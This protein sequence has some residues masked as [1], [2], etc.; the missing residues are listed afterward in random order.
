MKKVILKKLTLANWKGQTR[1]A[2][3]GE[4]ENNISGRNKSGKTTLMKAFYW[5]LSGYSDANTA[6][7]SDLFDNTKELTEHTPIASV[8]AV[9]NID[10][11][12][13]T[14]K[15]SAEAKCTRKRGTET[16]E[17]A[18]SD[19]YTYHIDNIER[20]STDFKAWLSEM[21]APE[22][23]LRFVL[24]GNFFI[25]EVFEDK[26]KARQLIEK[27]VG[28]VSRE[29]MK[30][31]YDI[32]DELIGR[33]TLDQIEMQATEMCKNI[34]QRLS[35]IPVAI[36]SKQNEIDIIAQTDFNAIQRDI[37]LLENEEK[38]LNAQIFDI[39]ARLKPQLEAK[40]KAE[41]G[42]RMATEIFEKAK[43]GYQQQFIDADNKLVAEIGRMD[44]ENEKT[45]QRKTKLESDNNLL[46]SQLTALNGTIEQLR[47]ERET[48]KNT[49]FECETVCPTCGAPISEEKINEAK[50]KFEQKQKQDLEG[51]VVRGKAVRAE[52]DRINAEIEKNAKEMLT[53]TMLDVEPVR[54]K[55][56]DLRMMDITPF[57]ETEQGVMLQKDINAIVIPSVEIPDDTA[58]KNRIDEIKVALKSLYMQKGTETRLKSLE[59]EIEGLHLEQREKGAELARYERQRKQVHDYK[60]EQIEILS[61]KVNDGLKFS[62]L[63][64][65]SKQKS[66]EIVPDLVIKDAQ[67]VNF[68]TTNQAS[69]IVT[70][71]DMQR[72][73][74]D[75]LCVNMPSWVDESSTINAD[76][77][78]VMNDVQLF[79]LFCADTS[80][81]I[82]SK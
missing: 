69:R 42:K 22:D 47:K 26:R 51:V 25:G 59:K 8:E 32:I 3:F 67:G 11:T 37:D 82:E 39:S 2:D 77:L 74:C 27:V 68:A 46:Q 33:Y 73:F 13:Y 40:S 43:S 36:E 38:D 70:A 21:I 45:R 62:R 64:V 79:Y 48:I 5:L 49:A 44:A 4:N 20:T 55:L 63:D 61:H 28:S 12:D 9:I 18:Y 50:A 6:M 24:D 17:K 54:Q 14:V 56:N 78:P 76:N 58:L 57:E 41:Q 71:L 23:M 10:G 52:I 60:Q 7:N 31:E 66:G 16:Y 81:K 15:R 75:R 35:E 34:N 53:L 19:T 29:E 1:T 30:G 72:F 80:L 65:W